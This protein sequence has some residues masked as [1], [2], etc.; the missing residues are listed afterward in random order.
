MFLF[1]GRHW[2]SDSRY[3][4]ILSDW[5]LDD[6]YIVFKAMNGSNFQLCC[7]LCKNYHVISYHLIFLLSLAIS[8]LDRFSWIKQLLGY[9]MWGYSLKYT[10]LAVKLL[11]SINDQFE[12]KWN[13]LQAK[14]INDNWDI[15][16]FYP[17]CPLWGIAVS[18]EEHWE[19]KLLVFVG[20]NFR[21]SCPRLGY[22]MLYSLYYETR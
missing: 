5:L 13:D 8:H 11:L 19:L 3:S 18:I 20:F 14:Q 4:T 12:L 21:S 1:S 22:L 6:E 17:I 15:F 9:F 2:S 16:I 7:F 10:Y